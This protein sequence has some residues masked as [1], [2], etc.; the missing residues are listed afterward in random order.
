MTANVI[1]T[2]IGRPRASDGSGQ[3]APGRT[4]RP[5]QTTSAPRLP[6]GHH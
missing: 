4:A 5:H 1:D 6:A 2:L 3:P